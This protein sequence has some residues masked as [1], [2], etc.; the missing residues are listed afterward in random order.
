MLYSID[1]L[2]DNLEEFEVKGL[3]F[4]KN[5]ISKEKEEKFVIKD[6]HYLGIEKNLNENEVF[7]ILETELNTICSKLKNE[8]VE[9]G[10]ELLDIDTEIS[11][12]NYYGETIKEIRIDIKKSQYGRGTATILKS[13]YLYCLDGVEKLNKFK[14]ELTNSNL[15]ENSK[16][17]VYETF[18]ESSSIYTNFYTII[19][20]EIDCIID[21]V[22]VGVDK[23]YIDIENLSEEIIKDYLLDTINS[24]LLN[25]LK[26]ECSKNNSLH[27]KI[28]FKLLNKEETLICNI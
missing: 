22:K 11:K 19:R 15:S 9:K 7:N 24:D 12:T 13:I 25:D 14:K 16:E 8:K 26:I 20:D 1:L 23:G 17:Y 2:K 18:I 27:N 4:L 3:D 28:S 10:R 6:N 5:I 21:N